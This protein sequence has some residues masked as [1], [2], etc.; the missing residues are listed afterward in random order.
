[1]NPTPT[2]R[3]PD[4]SFTVWPDLEQGSEAWENIRKGRPTASAASRIITPG[5][6]DSSQWEAYADQLIG[7]TFGDKPEWGGNHHTDRGTEL[8]PEALDRFAAS[9]PPHLI[10]ERVGFVTSH[11]GAVGCSPDALVRDS[12]TGSYVAGVE[13]KCPMAKNHIP[14][15]RS[16][17]VPDKHLPQIHWGMSVTG[18]DHWYFMSYHPKL[19]PFYARVDRDE[20]TEALTESMERFL[21][22]YGS[23]LETARTEYVEKATL[24]PIPTS[25]F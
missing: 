24:N 25:I 6:K 8:E 17:E 1:M 16:G 21:V 23:L 4:G 22:Y 2:H 10:V 7:E 14:V 3:E 11:H 5:G 13:I 20:Y 18:L 19:K 9:L 12:N 15:L